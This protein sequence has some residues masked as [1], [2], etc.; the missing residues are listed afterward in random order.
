[1]FR[2]LPAQKTHLTE[3]ESRPLAHQETGRIP[4]QFLGNVSPTQTWHALQ[5]NAGAILVDVRTRAE[6]AFVGSPDL[7][8]LGK[9]VVQVEWLVFPIMERNP[10]FV[11]ELRAQG[12]TPQESV[13]LICRSGVRS[14]QAA[15][16]LAEQGYTTYNVADGF[17][18]Q[19]DS[20]GHRGV[21]GW[22]AESLPWKQ[23]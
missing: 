4:G 18:G 20:N 16:L 7:A 10:G 5:D 3:V 21:G 2:V 1:M 19:I 22:R 11:K 12:I 23:T 15:E 14:R 17:E 13:Y 8:S 6:W 9:S